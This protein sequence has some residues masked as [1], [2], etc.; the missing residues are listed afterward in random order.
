M[1]E[2]L[3]ISRGGSGGVTGAKI[4]AEAALYEG[5]ESQAI[6]KYGSERRGAAIE[7]YVRFD[8]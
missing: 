5:V 1:I 4:L 6:P 8:D 7:A 2:L 3:Q